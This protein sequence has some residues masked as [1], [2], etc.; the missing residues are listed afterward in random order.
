MRAADD[1]ARA[2]DDEVQ[3]RLAALGYVGGSLSQRRLQQAAR[4]DP[5]DKI[6]LYNRLKRVAALSIEGRTDAAIAEA[7]GALAEDPHV[8]EAH[9]LLGNVY[10]KA[11]R[12]PEALSAYK[13]ALAAGIAIGKL[14]A[15]RLTRLADS[16]EEPR[17]GDDPAAD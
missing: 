4:D 9:L 3:E 5:K 12:L 8:V 14:T 2:L 15:P 11:R 17:D 6:G 7:R 10:R 16:D 1:L 13:A